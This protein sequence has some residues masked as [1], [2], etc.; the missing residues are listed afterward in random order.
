MIIIIGSIHPKVGARHCKPLEVYV[1]S[2]NKSVSPPQS[3][4]CT[5]FYAYVHIWIVK[6][7]IDPVLFG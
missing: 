6:K 5:L 4:A 2:Q 3:Y 7:E 1:F